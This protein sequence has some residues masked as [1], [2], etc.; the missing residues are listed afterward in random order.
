MSEK[1]REGNPAAF[2]A[3]GVCFLGAGVALST[4]LQSKG[5]SGIGFSLIGLGVVYL[6]LGARKRQKTQ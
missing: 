5:A 3:I 1:K 6:I 2:I 4:A